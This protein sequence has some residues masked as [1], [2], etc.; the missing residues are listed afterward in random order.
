MKLA[1]LNLLVGLLLIATCAG[2]RALSIDDEGRLILSAEEVAA[3]NRQGGCMV[4][5]RQYIEEITAETLGQCKA[6]SK[7]PAK[8]QDMGKAV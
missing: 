8:P 3:C 2:A 7:A 6:P 5:T 1:A 4:V